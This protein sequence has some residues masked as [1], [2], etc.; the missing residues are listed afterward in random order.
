MISPGL[1][2]L[3]IP[4]SLDRLDRFGS[5]TSPYALGMERGL[6]EQTGL[7]EDRDASLFLCCG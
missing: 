1:F 4:Q 7:P 6:R 3:D 2:A 5:L